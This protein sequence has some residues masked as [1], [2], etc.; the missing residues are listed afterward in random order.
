MK[1]IS[2][3]LSED[4][5]F[6][7]VKFSI[8]L[9]SRIF[10]M[11]YS[12]LEQFSMVGKLFGPLKFDYSVFLPTV[13]RRFLFKFFFACYSMTSCCQC[14]FSPLVLLVHREGCAS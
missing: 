1:N 8:Y 6:L 11:N 14:L 5:Q 12:F 3:F 9:N 7:E 2:F 13:P 10:V 4:V